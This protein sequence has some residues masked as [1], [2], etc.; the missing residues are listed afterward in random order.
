MAEKAKKKELKAIL[1]QTPEMLAEFVNVNDVTI[2]AIVAFDRFHALYCY[3]N[4]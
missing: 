1:F 4:N 2:V 3:N